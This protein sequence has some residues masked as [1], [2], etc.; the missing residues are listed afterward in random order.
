[1]KVLFF[2]FH[3]IVAH[4]GISKKIIAQKD[5]LAACG[6]DVSLIH[7]EL[8][9]DGTK[10]RVC[11]GRELR[12]FGGGIKSK[13]ARRIS[14]KDVVEYISKEG[15]ALVYMRYDINADP[16]SVNFVKEIKASGAKLVV[17]IPTWPYD[18]EFVG[19]RLQMQVQHTIEKCFRKRF[20]SYCDGIVTSSPAD[21]IFG[22]KTINLSN[23]IDFSKVPLRQPSKPRN[24]EIKMLSVANV[25]L[26]HGLDRLI[27]GMGRRKDI[28]ASLRIVGDGLE[29]IFEGYR[30]LVAKYGLEEKVTITGPMYGEELDREFDNADIAVGSLGRHRSGITDIKTLKNREYAARGIP[31]FFS[32]NDSDFTDAPYV[33][34]VPA[35]E[36]PVD[37]SAIKEF[38]ESLDIPGSE[39]RESVK[40]LSWENQMR[41]V[42]LSFPTIS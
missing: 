31:F 6:A 20:F 39:I 30:K 29:D 12:N 37:M 22:V 18:G 26:W 13:I 7:L 4:S 5:G 21:E 14:Y 40:E 11:N 41:K 38:L 2:V 42:L 28:N 17:E 24:D 15:I 8:N 33:L 36:S 35:D 3:S 16:F 9:A 27:E 23:G 32:E 10:S 34:K 19:Q 1:M 25:H